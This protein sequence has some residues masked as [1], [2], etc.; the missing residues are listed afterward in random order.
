MCIVQVANIKQFGAIL[1][2]RKGNLFLGSHTRI[3]STEGPFPPTE[4]LIVKDDFLLLSSDS[5]LE[6]TR[7][8]QENELIAEAHFEIE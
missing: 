6:L 7:R 3:K 8:K 4:K 1:F 2:K 5:A